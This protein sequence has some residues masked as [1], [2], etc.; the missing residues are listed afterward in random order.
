MPGSCSPIYRCIRG[1]EAVEETGH[2]FCANACL[3][4]SHYAKL[5]K[6]YAV[7]DDSGLEVDALGRVA[8][9]CTVPAGP[10]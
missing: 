7:A 1:R 9:R 2:T 6:T 4:A 10:K 8:G 5:F 3:K